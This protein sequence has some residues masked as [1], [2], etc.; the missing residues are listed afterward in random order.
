MC[1]D[2]RILAVKPS[3]CQSAPNPLKTNGKI[4]FATLQVISPVGVRL[5]LNWASA[6]QLDPCLSHPTDGIENQT[7]NSNPDNTLEGKFIILNTLQP[8]LS[9]QPSCTQYFRPKVYIGI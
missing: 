8:H 7:L 2:Q 1:I 4:I 3:S 6:S 5:Y 9:R